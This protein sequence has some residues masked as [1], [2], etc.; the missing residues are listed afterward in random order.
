MKLALGT[1]QF[2]LDYGIANQR[3]QVTSAEARSILAEAR[4]NGMTMLDTAIAYGDSEQRLGEI[5]IPGWQVVSKLPAV[6]DNCQDITRWVGECVQGSLQRLKIP[7][8]HGLLLH[9]PQQ[10]LQEGGDELYAA[11]QQLRR[12]GLVRKTGISI[13]GPDEL[14]ALCPRYSFELVQSPFSLVDR[15]LLRSGWLDKLTGQGT[16]VHVRSIFLQGLL[17]M[18]P[19]ERPRKFDRWGAL[20]SRYEAWLG[21]VGLSPLQVCVRYALSVAAIGQV[22]VGVDSLAQLREI[23]Q[24]A[25]GSCPAVPSEL[26]SEEP[27]LVSPARW[28]VLA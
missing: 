1:V 11:L 27:D 26:T 22:V 16:E 13:Y 3:G 25:N 5:G 14:D 21:Q 4:A 19:T 7:S 9:R 28:A 24:A 20:W 18:S 6:P 15:R 10:L 17:L 8:L 12:E 23:T 2:G